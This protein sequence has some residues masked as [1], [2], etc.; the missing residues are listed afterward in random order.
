MH[1]KLVFCLK[2]DEHSKPI[3]FEARWVCKGYE[4]VWGQDYTRTMS[5]T[6]HTESL[7]C[8]LHL[9]GA[10]DWNIFQVD[11]KTAFL[12]GTLPDDE[13]CFMEQPPGFK[14]LGKPDWVWHL[15]KGLY[16]LP[17][18]GCTWNRTMHAHL[19]SIG[20]SHL[21]AEYCLYS[22]TTAAGTV[23][24]GIHVDGM[25]S[26]ASS[27]T[28]PTEFITNLRKVW[29]ISDLGDAHF[30]VG[31]AITRDCAMHTVS[32]SQTVLIDQIVTQ[33]GLTGTH[34][35]SSPMESSCKLL[36]AQAPQTDNERLAAA[37]WPYRDSL[38]P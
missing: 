38:A 31:I 9:A 17:H 27:S 30:C 19:E 32:I 24:F 4:A 20:F 25:L 5:P 6:M 28:A 22:R 36:H 29:P 35:V 12:Y 11:V 3:C 7:H 21:S 1:G 18:G 14:E 8:L 15:R 16:G 13:I 26:I 37:F 33:F 10:L 2:H 23:I 34:P